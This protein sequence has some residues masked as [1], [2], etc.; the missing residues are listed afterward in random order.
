MGDQAATERAIVKGNVMKLGDEKALRHALLTAAGD[1][2]L[3]L[4]GELQDGGTTLGYRML[5]A[6]AEAIP[7]IVQETALAIDALPAAS[8]REVTF[9]MSFF[10][11]H[12]DSLTLWVEAQD[13]DLRAGR[14][15]ERWDAFPYTRAIEDADRV[16]FDAW[17]KP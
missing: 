3:E 10:Q 15:P 11:G 14:L 16:L 12:G 4:Q 6:T 2:C 5:V 7:T 13:A 17:R 8:T 9:S 1:L